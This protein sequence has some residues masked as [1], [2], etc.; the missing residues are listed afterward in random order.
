MLA[1]HGLQKNFNSKKRVNVRANDINCFPARL[2]F[3]YKTVGQNRSNSWGWKQ[4]AIRK[5]E[6]EDLNSQ[7][8]WKQIKPLR[9]SKIVLLFYKLSVSEMVTLKLDDL[10]F[11]NNNNQGFSK[12]IN[13]WIH[14][15]K[16][17][18]YICTLYWVIFWNFLCWHWRNWFN[19]NI[20]LVSFP[21]H[22][23][24]TRC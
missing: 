10:N 18:T 2:P 8:S 23:L 20:L 3:P 14:N 5:G 21:R 1:H 7:K 16:T 12:V 13:V 11:V 17:S 6:G 19:K 9:E 24:L 15:S 4:Q 22:S